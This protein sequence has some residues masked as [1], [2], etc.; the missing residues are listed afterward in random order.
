MCGPDGLSQGVA[1]PPWSTKRKLTLAAVLLA[2]CVAVLAYAYDADQKAKSGV[3]F[4]KH[5]AHSLKIDGA[6]AH[7]RTRH[8]GKKFAMGDPQL[9]DLRGW[10]FEFTL[11][12]PGER[13][14]SPDHHGMTKFVVKR[15][16]AESIVLGYKSSF[17]SQSGFSTSSSGTITLHPFDN[18]TSFETEEA[19]IKNAHQAQDIRVHDLRAS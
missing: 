14:Y 15:I 6:G 1:R 7:F 19:D 13:F 10:Q 5:S 8:F 17:T 9:N 12:Q 3:A 16:T 11:S 2:L 4:F 18:G